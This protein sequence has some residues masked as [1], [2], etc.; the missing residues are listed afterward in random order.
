[1]IGF[2]RLEMLLLLLPAAWLW[3]RTRD[4]ERGT[5]IL[6]ALALLAII[7]SLAGPYMKL[8]TPGRDLV[9][10]VDRSRSIPEGS[11]ESTEEFLRLAESARRAGDQVAIVTFGARTA[12]ERTL[13]ED[14]RFNGFTRE[15]L[16]DGSD[17]ALALETALEI[18][19][20]ARSGSILL[21]S[22]GEVRG[23]DPLPAARRAFGKNVR[24]DVIPYTRALESDLAIELIDLPQVTA[25]GEPFQ[26]SAWIHTDEARTAQY[27]LKRDGQLISRGEYNFQRGRNRLIFRDAVDQG[28]VST[29]QL[30]VLGVVDRVP[31][32]NSGL[33]AIRVEGQPR[34]LV[35]N[36]DG[37]EDTLVRALRASG[38]AVDCSRPELAPL[39]RLGLESYRGVILENVAASRLSPHMDDIRRFVDERGGG[40][41]VT[42]GRASFGIGG[43]YLSPLDKALPV[44]MELRKEQRKQG[45][46]LVIAMDRSGSMGAQSEGGTK[47]ELA[48]MGAAAAIDLLTVIDAVSVIAVDVEPA[49]VQEM[50]PLDDTS[51]LVSKVLRI[52]PG[53]GGINTRTAL[54]AA[55]RELEKAVQITKHITLFADASDANEQEGC[56]ALVEQLNLLGVTLSVIALGTPEDAHAE[57]LREIAGIGKGEIYFTTS[58][59]DLPRLFAQDTLNASRS[60]FIDQPVE[61]GVA[62]D[63]H[64]LGEITARDFPTIAGYNLCYLRPGAIAGLVGKDDIQAPIF[65]FQYEGLGRTAAYTGQIGGE[66]GSDVVQWPGFS[67]F[68]VTVSRWLMGQEAL[69]AIHGDVYREGREVV[70]RVEVDPESEEAANLGQMEALLGGDDGDADRRDFQRTSTST[71]EARF[72]LETYGIALPTLKIDN[73]RSVRLAPVSLPYS[74][75]HEPTPDPG[76]GERLMQRIAAESGGEVS[77]PVT[78][79]LRGEREGATWRSIARELLLAALI[80][81]LFEILFRRLG[82]WHDLNWFSSLRARLSR[83][84]QRAQRAA[85]SAHEAPIDSAPTV[86]TPEELQKKTAA[87]SGHA[88]LADAMKAARGRASRENRR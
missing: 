83:S 59:T 67:D 64:G 66:F 53:G 3:W 22:D 12:I 69:E 74:P 26:F 31:E 41:L 57:F 61:V 60:A 27:E 32:N 87:L 6:R 75:E 38:L 5:M 47:M 58:S 39:D 16:P 34:L 85:Q 80:I 18:I 21:L 14:G 2:Q 48:N 29:Y 46:A 43:Y 45:I 50:T 68:F 15:V 10:V 82:L 13:S 70:L 25:S 77:P 52:A 63:L 19:P 81:G 84:D 4:P 23:R 79:L 54:E 51:A 73:R 36:H 49:V 35:V 71:Y 44:S 42:G 55:T 76:N 8:T 56:A 17:L 40:L 30:E 1:M 20:E 9:I 33:G 37:K 65:A 88:K 11:Q 86:T 78:A 72:P 62:P 28:G 24:I 7:M